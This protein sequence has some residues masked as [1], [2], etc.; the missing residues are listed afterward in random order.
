MILDI[1]PA[2]TLPQENDVVRFSNGHFFWRVLKVIPYTNT[3]YVRSEG[4]TGKRFG[5]QSITN[6]IAIQRDTKYRPEPDYS[7]EY[8][9]EENEII[10][11]D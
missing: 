7:V 4:E 8:G 3:L 11:E 1:D 2:Y 5:V 9:A 10:L 6:V